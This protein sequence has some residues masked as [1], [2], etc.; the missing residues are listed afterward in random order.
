MR[1]KVTLA[2]LTKEERGYVARFFRIFAN[3][4][5]YS[6]LLYLCKDEYSPWGDIMFDLELN[7]KTL[8]DHLKILKSKIMVEH[9]KGNGFRT[10]D[11]G[12]KSVVL[13]NNLFER[14]CSGLIKMG[15]DFPLLST[16]EKEFIYEK[17]S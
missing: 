6:I 15:Y 13:V 14:M 4:N 3:E 1:E 9:Y 16:E 8:R 5:R 2:D 11:L 7:P 17:F 10:T 12:K